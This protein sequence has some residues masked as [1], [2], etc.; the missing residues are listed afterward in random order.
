VFSHWVLVDRELRPLA[1]L[2][3]CVA[4]AIKIRDVLVFLFFYINHYRLRAERSLQQAKVTQAEMERNL[5]L[6][7]LQQLQSQ[8]EPHFLFNTLAN[9]DALIDSN[10]SLA[11]HLLLQLNDLLR[12]TLKNNSQAL[13]S[14]TDEVALLNAYLQIQQ[15]RLG[16]R[17]HYHIECN[18]DSLQQSTIMLPPF[19]IQPVVENAIIH[20]IEPKNNQGE[21]SIGF[22]V[23]GDCLLVSVQDNGVGLRSDMVNS[24]HGIG[25]ANVRQRLEVLMPNAAEFTLYQTTANKTVAELSMPLDKLNAQHGV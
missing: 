22:S 21:V 7:Q 10:P 8:M 11:R 15:V 5:M 2:F 14:L 18:L 20:G 17:F 25:L 9:I 1:V 16:D 3:Q 19:L 13:I 4:L 24:G 23:K 6:S 12:A